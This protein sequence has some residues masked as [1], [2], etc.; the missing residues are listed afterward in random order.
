MTHTPS[1]GRDLRVCVFGDSYVHGAGD[2]TG[3]GVSPL[4]LRFSTMR[5]RQAGRPWWSARPYQ[6]MRRIAVES[7]G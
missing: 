4:W 1:T 7:G 3:A 2:P 6:R 5:T